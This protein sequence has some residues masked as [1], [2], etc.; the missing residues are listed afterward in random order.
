MLTASMSPSL[1]G[2]FKSASQSARVI[3]E[4]WAANNLFCPNCPSNQLSATPTNTQAIDFICP[5]CSALFQLKNKAS[6]IGECIPDAGYNAMVKSINSG[7]VPNLLI[8]HYDR[9]TWTAKN[10]MLVPHYAFSVSAIQKR[11]PLAETARRA[12]WVGCNILLRNIPRSAR[13]NVIVDST[14]LEPSS[15]RNCYDRLRPLEKLSPVQR[16]WTIDMLRLIQAQ[17]WIEFTTNQAY[18]CEDTLKSLY[19]SN[20]HI[21]E[22]IRQQLQVLRDQGLLIQTERGVWRVALNRLR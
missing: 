16:G 8:L 5:D 22:K 18:S 11:K 17:G 13:I 14:F 10:L 9:T 3:S 6:R 7:R 20:K 2:P 19:P 12:G 4:H 21:K 15:V 1:A